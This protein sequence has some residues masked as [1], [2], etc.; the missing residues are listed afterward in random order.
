M[1]TISGL[2][3]QH[4]TNYIDNHGEDLR[5]ISSR[6]LLKNYLK[7]VHDGGRLT[8]EQL[9]E[10]MQDVTSATAYYPGMV[11]T[12]FRS[13]AGSVVGAHLQFTKFH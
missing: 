8:D 10:G 6:L 2:Q 12:E 5:L 4:L 9:D 1:M 11:L 3:Q 7:I 13:V